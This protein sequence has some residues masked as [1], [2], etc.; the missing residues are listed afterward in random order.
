M[1]SSFKEIE[2]EPRSLFKRYVTTI[3]SGKALGKST[4]FRPDSPRTKEAIRLL[5]LKPNFHEI[6]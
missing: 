4:A 1:S 2:T 6:K 5:G 3:M